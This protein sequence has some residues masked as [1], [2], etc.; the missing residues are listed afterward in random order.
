MLKN[1]IHVAALIV[2]IGC[3]A[4]HHIS[5]GQLSSSTYSSLGVGVFNNSGL[6]QNQG[7]G[8]MGIS[9]GNSYSI[10]HV[11]P[12]VSVK[13]T[14]YGFQAALNYNK[15]TAATEL[16]SEDLDGGGLSYVAMSFPVVPRKVTLGFGLNQL[17]GVDYNIIVNT[18]VAGTDL[19]SKNTIVGTG[20]LSQVYLQSGFQVYKNLSLGV[21][22]AYTFGSTIRNNQLNLLDTDLNSVGIS[23]EYYERLTFSDVVFKG[24]A[25]YAQPLGNQQYLNIGAIYQI[26]GDVNGREFA[27]VAES[28]QASIPNSDGDVIADNVS[29]NVFIPAKLGYGVTYEKINKFA[30]GV[31]AQFQ[32]F[33]SFRAF[34]ASSPSG[35]MGKA[36]KFSLGG[37]YIPNA[38]S[39]ESLLS[40]STIRAGIEYERLPFQVNQKN[41]DDIGINFGTSIPIY[42]MSL[43]NLALKA[44][45]RGTVN[46]GLVRENYIK[47]SLGLSINDNSWFYKKVFE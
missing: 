11:N 47:V 18:P 27:K 14:A 32:D 38:F 12:A 46:D 29:G 5:Y 43:L 3:F 45:K 21:E 42:S 16:A 6:T 24:G 1:K 36:F 23:S 28:G 35:N 26:F 31:E 39:L 8:G 20:G 4:I 25:Y 41:V 15:L 7:M 17:T 37:Q 34:N 19:I 40:R 22:G 10:N 30:V 9:F 33:S 13:N 2:F 44:G